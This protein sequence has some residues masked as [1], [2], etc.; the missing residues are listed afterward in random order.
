MA[1]TVSIV[2]DD[3]QARKVLADWIKRAD[4]FR[5]ISDHGSAESAM[6]VL[7]QLKPC[8]VLMDI[9]LPGIDGVECVRRMKAVLPETQFVI[10]TGYED[11][12][13]IF[14]ALAAGVH[15]HLFYQTPRAGW[16]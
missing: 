2:E 3:D 10:L 13:H 12:D 4:G 11:A 8:V 5:F 7:P 15:R 16:R 14:Q 1:I 6:E 9:H